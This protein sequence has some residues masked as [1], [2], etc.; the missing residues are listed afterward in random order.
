MWTQYAGA[1]LAAYT[2]ASWW[3]LGIM[4]VFLPI[5]DY[6]RPVTLPVPVS[7][8]S[9]FRA[10]T[11][12][13]GSDVV[14][15]LPPQPS[16]ALNTSSLGT[17][18]NSSSSGNTTA[19]TQSMPVK[20]VSAGAIAGIVIGVV[21]VLALIGGVVFLL[22][23]KRTGS[24]GVPTRGTRNSQGDHSDLL[25]RDASVEAPHM[26]TLY[27]MPAPKQM[28][29]LQGRSRQAAVELPADSTYHYTP[30]MK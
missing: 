5:A 4:T 1:E 18:T 12:S 24:K 28:M 15:E 11:F 7:Q 25:D 10:K 21:A 8:M 2:I 3:V 27:E 16:V 29:E 17:L 9:C 6:A 13:P 26:N 20:M 19:G 30:S 22:R 14:V 23:R